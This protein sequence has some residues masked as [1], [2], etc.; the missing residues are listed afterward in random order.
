MLR[1]ILITFLLFCFY[2][3]QAWGVILIRSSESGDAF[4]FSSDFEDSTDRAQWTTDAN[5]PDYDYSSAGLSMT[6]SYVMRLANGEAAKRTLVSQKDDVYVVLQY[7]YEDALATSQWFLRI[8]DSGD[9]S[10]C[11][12]I[13]DDSPAGYVQTFSSAYSTNTDFGLVAD[14]TK[15]LKSITTPE[16]EQVRRIPPGRNTCI[17]KVFRRR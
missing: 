12:A 5:S 15:W 14:T 9:S 13:I 1:K 11:S 8:R 17:P 6:G 2:V 7:R 4:F 16:Q 10:L 3:S